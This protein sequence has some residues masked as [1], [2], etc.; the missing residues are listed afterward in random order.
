MATTWSVQG[1]VKDCNDRAATPHAFLLLP[2]YPCNVVKRD[3]GVHSPGKCL[4]I[5]SKFCAFLC[6]Y[7]TLK[8]LKVRYTIL[9][10]FLITGSFDSAFCR[11][12]L[13]LR[14]LFAKGQHSGVKCFGFVLV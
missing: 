10:I 1:R 14:K 7:A 3:Y 11:L 8:N 9:C 12:S 13:K 2:L 5:D 4:K 6:C